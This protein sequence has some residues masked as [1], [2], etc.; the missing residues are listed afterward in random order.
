ML[1]RGS[2]GFLLGRTASFLVSR[3]V[4]GRLGCLS[5]WAVLTGRLGIFTGCPAS[6]RLRCVNMGVEF[7]A[8]IGCIDGMT[9][10]YLQ[11]LC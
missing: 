1:L 4:G 7:I 11:H 2:H 6:C 9:V 8:T 10:A 3:L 5:L